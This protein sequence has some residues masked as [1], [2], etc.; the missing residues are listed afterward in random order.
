M[1]RKTLLKQTL[2]RADRSDWLLPDFVNFNV[3]E[4][5]LFPN[6]R[7]KDLTDDQ[8]KVALGICIKH[9]LKQNAN[10]DKM[11]EILEEWW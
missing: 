5:D 1:T 11:Q 7:V 6:I 2:C 9:I 3:V 10:L 4:D 8:A